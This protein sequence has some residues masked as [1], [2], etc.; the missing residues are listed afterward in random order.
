M[1]HGHNHERRANLDG[2]RMWI[3]LIR[4]DHSQTTPSKI[5][6]EELPGWAGYSDMSPMTPIQRFSN[7]LL[8]L[9]LLLQGMLGRSQALATTTRGAALVT[10]STDGIGV[11]TAKHLLAAGY[12]VLIHGRDEDR[13]RKAEK[14]IRSFGQG[15]KSR[16]W[17]LP[18]ADLATVQGSRQL[19]AD[20]MRV[21]QEE[22]FDLKVLMNNAGVYSQER[23]ITSDGTELTFAVNVVAPFVITSRLLATMIGRRIVIASSISQCGSIRDWDDLTYQ[24]R[25]YSAHGAYSESKL[26]DAMLTFEFADRFKDKGIGTD[27][28]TCNC[29]DPGTVNTKVSQYLPFYLAFSS[30]AWKSIRNLFMRRARNRIIVATPRVFSL[31]RFRPSFFRALI[32]VIIVLLQKMLLAG[33]GPCGIDVQ[34]ALDQTWLCSSDEVQGVTGKYFT[35][36]SERP[37]ARSAY[38]LAERKRMWS[39]LSGLAPEEAKMWDLL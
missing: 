22:G 39:I 6:T 9:L 24:K 29:L 13:I 11:T 31:Y 27:I 5:A 14:T 37:A 28:V 33:W 36:Q 21:C 4:E 23:V 17:A 25:P 10:G 30:L 19:A 32:F 35:Y 26:L 38:D 12:D 16:V 8:L 20:V 7:A 3:L 18:A 15:S 2:S 1:K 34:S